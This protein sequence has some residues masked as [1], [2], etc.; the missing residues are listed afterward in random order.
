MDNIKVAL[1]GLYFENNFGDPI[2]AKCTEWLL[3]NSN[4]SLQITKR[5]SLDKIRI[6]TKSN[7]TLVS[8]ICL[9]VWGRFGYSFFYEKYLYY[10]TYKYFLEQ[11]QDVDVIIIVGGGLIK[12]KA[13]YFWIYL[14]AM[15]DAAEK[16]GKKVI[17]NAVG[18]EGYDEDDY[19]CQKLKK[20]LHSFSVRHISTRDDYKTLMES[21]FDGAPKIACENVADPAVWTSECY[22]IK[23]RLDNKSKVI[24]LGVARGDIFRDHGINVTPEEIINI[25][26]SIAIRLIKEGYSVEI[27]T[28]G[29]S[30]DSSM[31]YEVSNR[32]QN[33]GYQIQSKIPTTDIELIDMISKYKAIIATRL[34]SCIIAYS[35]E[36]PAIGLVWNDKLKLFGEKIGNPSYFIT[37]ENFND[38]FII[39]NLQEAMGQEYDKSIRDKFRNTIKDS[40]DSFCM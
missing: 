38:A 15:I 31:V 35:L 16:L 28:N 26:S 6:Q 14:P 29:A 34:H 4:D 33:L 24:G 21:Y 27:Y 22:G 12:Y 1:V 39:D 2:I 20:A 18:V 37:Y 7:P 25:Y 23:K 13:Q 36:V 3:K 5:L 8:R 9:S 17:V 30:C 19:R 10:F 40:I 32:V 11:L